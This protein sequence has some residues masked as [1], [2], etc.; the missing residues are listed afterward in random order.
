[1]HYAAKNVMIADYI[2]TIPGLVLIVLSGG[3]MTGSLGYSLTGLNWLTFSLILFAVTG[4]IWL[5]ILIPMQRKMI[6]LSSDDIESG[7]VSAAYRK[8]SRNWA[9]YGTIATLLPLVILYLMIS[10]GF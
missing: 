4:L 3:M 1:M 5:L 9:V 7:T 8:A 2:F 6:R 10:K